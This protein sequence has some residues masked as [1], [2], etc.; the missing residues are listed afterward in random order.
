MKVK[1]P[2]CKDALELSHNEHEEGDIIQC[3]ECSVDLIVQVKGGKFRVVTEKE[4]FFEETE[5]LEDEFFEED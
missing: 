4:R 3:P 5:G 2:E 1:C